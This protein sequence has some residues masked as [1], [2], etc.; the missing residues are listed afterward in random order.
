MGFFK[1][2]IKRDYW[3]ETLDFETELQSD[4]KKCETEKDWEAAMEKAYYFMIEGPPSE[5]PETDKTM[6]Q[7]SGN[8]FV[9]TSAIHLFRIQMCCNFD[10]GEAYVWVTKG[11]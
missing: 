2:K 5:L 7:M 10:G 9:E 3:Q 8:E 4:F 11:K 6:A 1:K